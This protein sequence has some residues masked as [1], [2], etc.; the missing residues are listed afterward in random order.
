MNLTTDSIVE[1]VE[2]T[3]KNKAQYIEVPEDQQAAPD[4]S[5]FWRLDMAY[6]DVGNLAVDILKA[7]EVGLTEHFI[8]DILKE[9]IENETKN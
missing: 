5:G 6:F 7:V 2:A 1:M 3:I 9:R 8:R 4:I